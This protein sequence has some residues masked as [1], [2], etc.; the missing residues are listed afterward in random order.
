MHQASILRAMRA[1]LGLSQTDAAEAV[2]LTRRTIVS[3]EAGEM[4]DK[5][6]GK[7]TAY[8]ADLGLE[9]WDDPASIRI[10]LGS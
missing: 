4:T 7:L 2:G 5:T 1:Y 9:W 8:Y 10:M 6:W 3:A